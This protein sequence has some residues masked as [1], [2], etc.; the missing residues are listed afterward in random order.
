[1]SSDKGKGRAADPADPPAVS[2]NATS[3]LTPASEW[4][5]IRITTSTVIQTAVASSLFHLYSAGR[6]AAGDAAPSAVVL[7][8]LPLHPTSAD[9]ASH[10]SALNKKAAHSSLCKLISIVEI[11]KREFRAYQL[12][13][14]RKEGQERA[15]KQREKRLGLVPQTDIDPENGDSEADLQSLR[16]ASQK[17]KRRRVDAGESAMLS[18]IRP[19]ASWNDGADEE[20]ALD[21]PGGEHISSFTDP[22]PSKQP[23]MRIYAYNQL[24]TWENLRSKGQTDGGGQEAAAAPG[25]EYSFAAEALDQAI[26]NQVAR[27]RKR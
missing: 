3:S 24:D 5:S 10:R 9:A 25:A 2:H 7:H 20:E 19:E 13:A 21:T 18:D 22:S 23:V 26:Q 17:R 16:V 8:T 15:R 12:E 4:K 11:I 14:R 27:G 1:M 6:A